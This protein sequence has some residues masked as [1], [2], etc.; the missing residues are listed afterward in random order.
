MARV[1]HRLFPQFFVLTGLVCASTAGAQE[2]DFDP[3]A[4]H[5]GLS[6]GVFFADQDMDTDFDVDFGDI[7]ANVDFEE[8][9]GLRESQQVGRFTMFRNFRDR[10]QLDLDV[11]DLS[12]NSNKIL[13]TS[14]E[15]GGSIFPVSADV[16]TALDLRIYKIAYSYYLWRE[17]K[18]RL[19]ATG[20]LYIADIGL[21]MRWR[22][23]DVDEVGEITAPLP[24]FGI[25]GEY[26]FSDRWRLSGSAEW[27]G[28]EIDDYDGTLDDVIVSLDYRFSERTALGVGY[29]HV[30][31]NVDATEKHLRAD[32]DWRYSG[33]FAHLRL[34]F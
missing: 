26:Y 6:V 11:F 19:G 7:S 28:L 3:M 24:V 14:I 8:D 29:N 15:W 23:N 22:D 18:F 9:L 1:T 5:W 33:Y 4:D 12:Q 31:I 2:S 20:G 27:F 21:R 13:E 34:I 25:R 16:G 17:P 10:H 32:L 30:H